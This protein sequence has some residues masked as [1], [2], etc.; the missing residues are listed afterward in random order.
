MA[1]SAK[2][3]DAQRTNFQHRFLLY[4]N[5]SLGTSTAYT[6]HVCCLRVRWLCEGNSAGQIAVSESLCAMPAL[7]LPAVL[8]QPAWSLRELKHKLIARH[9]NLA[10]S[11]GHCDVM[12]DRTA[13]HLQ[14]QL[15]ITAGRALRHVSGDLAGHCLDYL[16]ICCGTDRI[17][18]AFCKAGLAA[19]GVDKCSWA[20]A[21]LGPIQGRFDSLCRVAINDTPSTAC[22]SEAVLQP[23]S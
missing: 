5:R 23:W 22:S 18:K 17:T 1:A 12:S 21:C 14:D 19:A 15:Y 9:P 20:D 10:T 13:S 16:H 11:K 7:S 3:T 2:R 6:W 8:P 4:R